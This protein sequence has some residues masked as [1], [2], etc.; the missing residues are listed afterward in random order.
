LTE[1]VYETA[2]IG[3]TRKAKKLL[4][5]PYKNSFARGGKGIHVKGKG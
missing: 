5:L 2:S 3:K 4:D 1:E